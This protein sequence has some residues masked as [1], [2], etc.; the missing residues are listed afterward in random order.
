M[1]CRNLRQWMV[2]SLPQVQSRA[3]HCTPIPGSEVPHWDEWKH[4]SASGGFHEV[5]WAVVGLAP[6]IQEAHHCAKDTAQGGLSAS[7]EWLLT[8]SGEETETHFW[9]LLYA[10]SWTMVALCMTFCTSP[11]SRLYTEANEAPLEEHRLKLSMHYYLKTCAC[12]DHP[13]H[14][15]LH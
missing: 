11:V 9:R 5:L 10:P 8:W 2:S 7:S 3:F 6:L 4:T 1:S 14:H 15:A 12:I 13:A